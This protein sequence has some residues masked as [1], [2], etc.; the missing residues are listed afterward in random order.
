MRRSRAAAR[1][2]RRPDETACRALGLAGRG[3]MA[4]FEGHE[5]LGRRDEAESLVGSVAD[6][7]A[8]RAAVDFDDV[9]VGHGGSFKRRI[10]PQGFEH[11]RESLICNQITKSIIIVN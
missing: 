7:D 2:R 6:D 9:S 11:C 5:S 4:P 8:G 10:S 1:R 3:E